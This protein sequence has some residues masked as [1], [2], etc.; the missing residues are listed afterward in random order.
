MSPLEGGVFRV[1]YIPKSESVLNELESACDV[2]VRLGIDAVYHIQGKK[3]IIRQELDPKKIEQ[4]KSKIG[5]KFRLERIENRKL[6]DY[7]G[8]K[9]EAHR[10]ENLTF[11]LDASK[12]RILELEDDLAAKNVALGQYQDTLKASE[13]LFDHQG[14]FLA[15]TMGKIE[16][17]EALVFTKDE[18]LSTRETQ[19]AELQRRYDADIAKLTHEKIDIQSSLIRKIEELNRNTAEREAASSQ[20]N[21]IPKEVQE[22]AA[23][24]D[25]T[26]SLKDVKLAS[27]ESELNEV[28]G[29]LAAETLQR[30]QARGAE[31]RLLK[32]NGEFALLIE[33]INAN[34]KNAEERA[35]QAR[36]EARKAREFRNLAEKALKEKE[37]A[38]VE[39]ATAFN[40][41]NREYDALK[42]RAKDL[43]WSLSETTQK[44]ATVQTESSR[45][46]TE[47]K[48]YEHLFNI[49][50]GELAALKA[51]VKKISQDNASERTTLETKLR[52]LATQVDS[53]QKEYLSYKERFE[54]ASQELQNKT[55]EAHLL[56]SQVKTL[57]Q[58]LATSCAQLANLP[59]AEEAAKKLE[60]YRAN[61]THAAFW[62]SRLVIALDAGQFEKIATAYDAAFP[63]GIE[64]NVR[65]GLLSY[66][67]YVREDPKTRELL[68]KLTIDPDQL[69]SIRDV[70]EQLTIEKNAP[71]D[72]EEQH[73]YELMKSGAERSEVEART[74]SD[75]AQRAKAIERLEFGRAHVRNY[76]QNQKVREERAKYTIDLIT[77]TQTLHDEHLPCV[78]ALD[79]KHL[80]KL[81][82]NIRLFTYVTEDPQNWYGRVVLPLNDKTLNSGAGKHL[83]MH[84]GAVV[85]A[86]SLGRLET[87]EG[88][89]EIIVAYDKAKWDKP[90]MLS[91]MHATANDLKGSF[92]TDALYKLGVAIRIDETFQE[93]FIQ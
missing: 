48:D 90:K 5:G 70:V 25:E 78:A 73:T 52:Q 33:K 54:T 85:L 64:D 21:T 71:I 56:F 6:A 3:V 22:R 36:E 63:Q 4:A 77:R 59:A 32:Q 27:L 53:T 16:N 84:A 45:R 60:T 37:R 43:E 92:A 88:V 89:A 35:V 57:D 46:E 42:M 61:E 51:H 10:H 86:R 80:P 20:Q 8:H 87:R 9:G 44:L 1:T 49:R 67:E 30:E 65:A 13:E 29:K 19:I 58:A 23:K 7:A 2:L 69:T 62:L 38:Y 12:K 76:L 83:V 39:K 47:M 18:L 82:G 14:G 75:Q 40:S 50:D 68:T 31:H 26:I 28:K 15:E 66:E 79:Q 34:E 72:P 81:E 93:V 24:I 11:E 41:L 74:L 17:L 91:S 55:Q